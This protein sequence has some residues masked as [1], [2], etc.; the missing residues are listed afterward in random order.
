MMRAILGY[1]EGD[2]GVL[3]FV[4]PEPAEQR[5][6][7]KFHPTREAAASDALRLNLLTPKAAEE[8]RENPIGGEGKAT[9]IGIGRPKALLHRVEW[10][11]FSLNVEH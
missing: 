3:A 4:I 10:L 11:P 8:I 5:A 9:Q 2:C 1:C 6:W 7:V